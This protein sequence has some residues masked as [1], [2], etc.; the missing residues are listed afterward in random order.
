[1]KW[2][3]SGHSPR[4]GSPPNCSWSSRA[5]RKW[6]SLRWLMLFKDI[7]S[8]SVIWRCSWKSL[9]TCQV[10]LEGYIHQWE[11]SSPIWCC[12]ACSRTLSNGRMWWRKSLRAGHLSVPSGSETC[13]SSQVWRPPH[14]SALVVGPRGMQRCHSMPWVNWWDVW[15]LGLLI[16]VWASCLLGARSGY[17]CPCTPLVSMAP[18]CRASCATLLASALVCWRV[19]RLGGC[20]ACSRTLSCARS[21]RPRSFSPRFFLKGYC[22][23]FVVVW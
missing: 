2:W 19:L 13:R 17:I 8:A 14:Q 12:T 23:T 9:Q 21:V 7:N 4:G 5:S 22:I 15:L 11:F 1:M 18:R 10:M 6:A 20:T 16:P 3:G